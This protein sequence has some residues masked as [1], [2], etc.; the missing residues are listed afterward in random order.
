VPPPPPG[1]ST[2][3]RPA[4]DDGGGGGRNRTGLL[5]GGAI[6]VLALVAGGLFLLTRGDDE[7]EAGPSTEL[8]SPGDVTVP[9]DAT[10]P[11]LSR[12]DV[13]GAGD[14]TLPALTVPDDVTD[15]TAPDVTS[16]DFTIP[17]FTMPDFTI[18]DLSIPDMPDVIPP[19]DEA[20]TGLGD[21]PE[22]DRLA[23]LCYDGGLIACD[24]LYAVS[25]AGS[26]YETY[27]DTCAGRQAAATNEFCSAMAGFPSPTQS[28]SD[29]DTSDTNI[30]VLAARCWSGNMQACD[31]LSAQA[32]A[33]SPEQ[34]FGRTCAGRQ[35]DSGTPC[36]QAL[37]EWAPLYDPSVVPD[38]QPPDGLGDDPEFDRLAQSCFEGDFGACDD[39]YRQSEIDSAYEVYGETCGGRVS[40]AIPGE[41]EETYGG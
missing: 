31:D 38:P 21:E 27:G 34:S 39:L 22:L 1:F 3:P 6:L 30:L 25:S 12:P 32:P 10:V 4:S 13:T 37:P 15:V 35:D 8:T 16:P 33:G 18:P 11:E 28:P 5:I 9:D 29:L 7:D 40:Q 20:P 2:G 24:E 23:Q 19:A 41:C 17:D 26:A 36:T 14:V